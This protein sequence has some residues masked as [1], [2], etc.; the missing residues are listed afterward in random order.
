MKSKS[1][2]RTAAQVITYALLIL[3]AVIM[4]VPFVWMI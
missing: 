2:N 4:L 1:K 3:L